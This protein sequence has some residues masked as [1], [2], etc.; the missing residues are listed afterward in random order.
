M[1]IS[2]QDVRISFPRIEVEPDRDDALV[3]ESPHLRAPSRAQAKDQ[4]PVLQAADWRQSLAQQPLVLRFVSRQIQV[5]EFDLLM[6]EVLLVAGIDPLLKTRPN[7]VPA[8]ARP[9]IKTD[10]SEQLAPALR[11]Q[12]FCQTRRVAQ[13]FLRLDD[14]Q[15][16]QRAHGR[17]GRRRS[18]RPE[19]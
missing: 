5:L 10:G 9:G 14:D 7:G 4:R 8:I 11:A 17:N 6:I 1:K 19:E 12:R 13:D 2:A 3:S 16:S 15:V 18:L